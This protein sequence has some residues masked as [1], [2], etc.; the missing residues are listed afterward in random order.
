MEV[1]W[2]R[3]TTSNIDPMRIFIIVSPHSFILGNLRWVQGIP[4]FGLDFMHH[5]VYFFYK[6]KIFK[7]L[8]KSIFKLFTRPRKQYY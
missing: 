8:E 2:D 1:S 4:L 7:I 3:E 5:N 6:R